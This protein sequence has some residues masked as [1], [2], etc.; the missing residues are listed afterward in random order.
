M[1]T[2]YLKTLSKPIVFSSYIYVGGIILYNSA[3]AYGD[4]KL[5]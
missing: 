1:F 2:N 3:Y 4:S 5:N